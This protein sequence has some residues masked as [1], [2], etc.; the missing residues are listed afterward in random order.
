MYGAFYPGVSFT[1]TGNVWDDTGE[2][3]N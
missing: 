2:P 3:V 1:K